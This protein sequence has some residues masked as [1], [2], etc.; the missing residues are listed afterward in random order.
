M[1]KRGLRVVAIDP[2]DRGFGFA[3][4]EGRDLLLD[5]GIAYL[6]DRSE[7]NIRT[8][9]DEVITRN[10]PDALVIQEGRPGK[11][12]KGKKQTKAK[13]LLELLEGLADE[14]SLPILRV[15]RGDIRKAFIRS[16][17][18][19]QIA[20]TLAALHPE[21]LPLPRVRRL[22]TNEAERMHI[23]DAVSLAFAAL[24]K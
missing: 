4:F 19:N 21:L 23:F 20:E 11:P 3:A 7:S 16:R 6:K 5:W 18:K 8:Y 12:R 1:K 17:N 13:R 9:L 10:H 14:R 22:W 2:C 24:S 15:S